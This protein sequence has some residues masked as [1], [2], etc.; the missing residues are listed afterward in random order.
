MGL[1]TQPY[2]TDYYST[3]LDPGHG[4]SVIESAQLGFHRPRDNDNR[5]NNDLI[6]LKVLFTGLSTQQD[7]Y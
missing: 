3:E 7:R 6:W 2:P 1:Q 5:R 4:T